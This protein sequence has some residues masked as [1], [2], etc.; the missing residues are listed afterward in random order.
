[1][2]WGEGLERLCSEFMVVMGNSLHSSISPSLP[3]EL[4]HHSNGA[5]FLSH[6]KVNDG[7]MP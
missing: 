5:L 1:M 6:L 3:A 2:G 4:C 7:R